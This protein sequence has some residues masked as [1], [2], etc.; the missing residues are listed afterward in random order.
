M[1]ALDRFHKRSI[2]HITRRS[3]QK[4][5]DGSW[6]YPNHDE[7]FE[8]FILKPIEEYIKRRRW[9]LRQYFELHKT[10]R[11]EIVSQIGPPARDPHHILKWRQP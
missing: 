9:T 3:I 1:L 6:T 10:K 11:L 4:E 5:R 7:L 8:R 2:R